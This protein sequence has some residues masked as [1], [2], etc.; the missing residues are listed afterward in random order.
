MAALALAYGDYESL[1]NQDETMNDLLAADVVF[2]GEAHDD[3][4]D[5]ET[6]FEITRLLARQGGLPWL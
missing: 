1:V 2:I 5:M 6:A 3:R 4:R